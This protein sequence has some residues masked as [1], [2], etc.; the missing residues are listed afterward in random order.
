MVRT[1]VTNLLRYI[2]HSE[3][4]YLTVDNNYNYYCYTIL[5]GS[6]R[7]EGTQPYSVYYI[8]TAVYKNLLRCIKFVF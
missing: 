4:S 8:I 5:C 7:V 1:N 6:V 3:L 2:A